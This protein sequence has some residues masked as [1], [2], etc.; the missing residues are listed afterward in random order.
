MSR[1]LV[2]FLFVSLLLGLLISAPASALEKT[3]ARIAGLERPDSWNA[4]GS[5]TIR[6]YN[7]CTGWVWLWSSWSPNERMGVCFDPPG[8]DWFVNTTWI[9]TYSGD[10]AGYGFTGTISLLD[11]CDCSALPLAT[12][13]YRPP[14]TSGWNATVW[15][16]VIAPS[17]F[18][19]SISWGA[20]T[21]FTNPTAIASDHPF[22]GP[23][24]PTSCGTCFPSNRTV[25]SR[26]FGTGGAYCP[27]GTTLFDGLCD[28]E[29]M[30]DVSLN[31]V[32]PV[33]DKSWGGVK[34]LYR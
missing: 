10:P 6:Y 19:V 28:I 7:N 14:A 33:E 25:H 4:G 1:S 15:G 2:S 8:S 9:L 17:P 5:T 21:G 30:L 11:G 27:S 13:P 32:D 3:S 24:G 23:T 26:Y 20:P 31:F 16:G 12:Q 34:G 29:F 18:M 22:A